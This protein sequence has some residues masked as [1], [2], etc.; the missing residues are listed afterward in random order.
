MKELVIYKSV[1]MLCLHSQLCT[2]PFSKNNTPEPMAALFTSVQILLA[3]IGCMFSFKILPLPFSTEH[4][5]RLD[6]L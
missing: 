5:N 6:N 3:C 1:D 2:Y 4:F